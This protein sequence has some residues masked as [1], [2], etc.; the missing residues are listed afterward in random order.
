ML[1]SELQKPRRSARP[2]TLHSSSTPLALAHRARKLMQQEIAFIP[3]DEFAGFAARET[4]HDSAERIAALF[5]NARRLTKSSQSLPMPRGFFSLGGSELLEPAEETQLFREMNFLKYRANILRCGIDPRCPN[6]AELDLIERLLKL[7]RMARDRIIQA[8][9][10]L[11]LS[12]AKQYSEGIHYFDDLVSDGCHTLLR[13]VEKFDYSRGFRLSTYATHAIRRNLYQ[14]LI[15]RK[16]ERLIFEASPLEY[17]ADLPD[18]HES[19]G[20]DEARW[21]KLRGDLS[22]LMH[23]LDPREKSIIN[24]RFGL[25]RESQ[26]RTLQ[27]LAADLGVCKER[28]RQLEQRALEKLRY[29]ADE[30][31]I[32]DPST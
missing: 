17:V 7:S 22:S 24:A 3:S 14:M 8:N 13:A 20:T 23:C 28:V 18:E 26:P 9:L 6:E 31:S 2:R 30:L 1:T 4:A 10:R 25:G 16:K 19:A 29:M 32:D 27:S 12:L 11:V 5:E 15:R 21:Q